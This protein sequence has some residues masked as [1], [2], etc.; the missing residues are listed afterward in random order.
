MGT[1]N[2]KTALI[3]HPWG[4]GHI[5][6][7]CPKG[8]KLRIKRYDDIVRLLCGRLRQ[9]GWRV[10]Q[11]PGIPYRGTWRKP[12]LGIWRDGNNTARVFDVQVIADGYCLEAAQRRKVEKYSEQPIID[13]I[14]ILIG[15]PDVQISAATL[16]RRG[17]M[18]G[19]AGAALRGVGINKGDL[20]I[21]AVKALTWMHSI[22]QA[23][24]RK[25]RME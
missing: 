23:Y 12:D 4:L 13:G 10:A 3:E 22:F 11:E 21:M 20:Q 17:C 2:T 24:M 16:N 19:S 15:C 7:T 14:R 25:G 18:A 8:Y 9:R 6:Q 5:S 1:L